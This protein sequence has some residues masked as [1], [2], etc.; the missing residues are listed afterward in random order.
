MRGQRDLRLV[1][2]LSALCAVVGF[3]LPLE[4]LAL[5]F[6][7]PL[8]LLLPG[9]A[10]TAATFARRE[11]EWPQFLLLSL[12]LSL[13][14]LVLGSLLL[15]YV[16][17]G[18]RGL[19]WSLLLLA[20]VLGCCRAAAL[21]RDGKSGPPRWPRPRLGGLEIGLLSGGLAAA[22]AA[23][24]L[25]SSAV[26]AKDAV[27]YTQL[28]LLPEAGSRGAEVQVGVKSQEQDPVD[29]DL[30]IRVGNYGPGVRPSHRGPA[31]RETLTRSFRL[32]PGETRLTRISAPPGSTAAKV[33]VVA[34]LLRHNQP[35]TV[36]RRV[37]GWLVAQKGR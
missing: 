28:W 16:P 15:N 19:S 24:I 7:A 37:K 6:V 12:A 35:F 22:A 27:G 33:P 14:V 9:Y 5:V 4:G 11:L 8:A 25:A 32:D 26:P 13:T 23:V 30:R 34:T 20:V 3:L 17:G 21:R 36:Y 1:L 18:I 31:T 29:Y 2:A 10:I